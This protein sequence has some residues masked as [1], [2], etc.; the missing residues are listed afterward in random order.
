[1]LSLG[2]AVGAVIRTFQVEGR[3]TAIDKILEPMSEVHRSGAELKARVVYTEKQ[4]DE[5]KKHLESV[6]KENRDQHKI[7]RDEN[8][9]AH[10]KILSVVNNLKKKE[11]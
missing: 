2:I 9:A 10:D 5:L 3:V 6:R 8:A 4:V 1:M 7:D 11:E